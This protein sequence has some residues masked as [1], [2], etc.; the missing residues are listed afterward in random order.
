MRRASPLRHFVGVARR[1]VRDF[2]QFHDFA[3]LGLH[4]RCHRMVRPDS[5]AA[6]EAGEHDFVARV[7][8]RAHLH[9]VVGD[10]AE[11]MAQVEEAPR[12]APQDAQRPGLGLQDGV[13]VAR[14]QLDQGGFAAAV[15]TQDGDVLA[16]RDRE[17]TPSK[18][19]RSS[20]RTVTFSSSIRGIKI[21]FY[22][23]DV[24]STQ[25]RGDA[26]ISAEK[27]KKS[28]SFAR[29]DRLKPAPP[30]SSRRLGLRGSSRPGRARLVAGPAFRWRGSSSSGTGRRRA[31][32]RR[33]G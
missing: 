20:R 30:R 25:R 29:I 12:V 17:V 33:R 1:Q 3:R 6:E 28:P 13:E 22:P 2:E 11:V 24:I 31:P 27:R 8:A 15:G 26:E 9:P 14:D 4:L 18:A 32:R 21:S 16:L 5:H 23:G 19:M 7:V 10:D